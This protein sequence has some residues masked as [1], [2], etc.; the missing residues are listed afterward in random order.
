M[1]ALSEQ[2]I[3]LRREGLSCKTTAERLGIKE[4]V[5]YRCMARHGLAGQFRAKQN[6][7]TVERTRPEWALQRALDA[8]DVLTVERGADGGYIVTLDEI[9]TGEERA[10]V[11]GAIG[12]ALRGVG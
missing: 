5:V 8:H 4:Y 6:R 12:S 1:T 11:S 9:V 10:T 7:T 3:A 2:I